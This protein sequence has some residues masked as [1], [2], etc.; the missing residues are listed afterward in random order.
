ME[1]SKIG[2][3]RL[4]RLFCAGLLSL[5]I[6]TQALAEESFYRVR[7]CG[8][9]GFIDKQGRLV[10]QPA[11]DFARRFQDGVAPVKVGEKWGYIDHQGKFVIKPQYEETR[12]F[13][14]GIAPV[15]VGDRWGFINHKNEF[16]IPPQFEAARS[17]AEPG[18]GMG[19][20]ARVLLNGR[21]HLIDDKGHDIL[22]RDFDDMGDRSKRE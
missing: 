8:K 19:N 17:F 14:S 15:R 21:W 22:P 9:V 12:M 11:F 13:T 1:T 5:C 7:I 16:V 2:R 10:V 4:R 20:T 6:T 3:A 18:D